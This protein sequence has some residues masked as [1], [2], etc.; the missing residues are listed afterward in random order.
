M[1]IITFNELSG[2]DVMMIGSEVKDFNPVTAP[3]WA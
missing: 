3:R 2:E 1:I